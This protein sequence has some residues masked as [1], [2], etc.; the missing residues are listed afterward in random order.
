MH[1]DPKSAFGLLVFEHTGLVVFEHTGVFV[2]IQLAQ[3]SIVPIPCL[4]LASSFWLI[5]ARAF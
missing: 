2:G 5:C 1:A 4:L 3:A